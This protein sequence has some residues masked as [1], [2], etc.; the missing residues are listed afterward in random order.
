[1][2]PVRS[3]CTDLGWGEFSTAEGGGENALAEA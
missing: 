3:T 1:M 2:Q